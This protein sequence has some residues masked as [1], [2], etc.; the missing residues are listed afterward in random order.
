MTQISI[1]N[2]FQAVKLVE[3]KMRQEKQELDGMI[4]K[5]YHKSYE[6]KPHRAGSRNV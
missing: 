5:Y 4:D 3:K 2:T 1:L 6:R